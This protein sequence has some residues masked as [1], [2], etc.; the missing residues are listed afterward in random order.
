MG[1]QYY[2]QLTLKTANGTES[3]A[4]FFMGNNRSNA[5]SIFRKLKG[6]KDVT[7]K[8]VM[9][10]D[11]METINGLPSS[12]EIITCTLNQ[13]GENCKIITKELFKLKI[14]ASE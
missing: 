9:Y 7:E 4:K 11:F 1:T 12:I 10:M 8:D 5:I 14:L 13:I 6:T 2:I 3:F